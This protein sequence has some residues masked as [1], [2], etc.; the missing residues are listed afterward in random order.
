MLA[1]KWISIAKITELETNESYL[2]GNITIL[3]D[4]IQKLEDKT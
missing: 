2:K 1:N 4:D 3:K